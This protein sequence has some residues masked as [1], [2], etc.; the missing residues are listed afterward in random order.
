MLKTAWS[1]VPHYVLRHPWIQFTINDFAHSWFYN[2]SC[3]LNLGVL[4]FPLASNVRFCY[5]LCIL[6]ML[7]ELW[8]YTSRPKNGATITLESPN[9]CLT[10][11]T[12]SCPKHYNIPH[13]ILTRYFQTMLSDTSRFIKNNDRTACTL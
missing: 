11:I 9:F 6:R 7:V 8:W 12:I 13:L 2:A 5:I 1:V 10:I 4:N 3:A